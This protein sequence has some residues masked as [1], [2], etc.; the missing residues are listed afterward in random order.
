MLTLTGAI[1]PAGVAGWVPSLIQKLKPRRNIV[2]FILDTNGKLKLT[3][4]HLKL[5]SLLYT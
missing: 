5:K 1:M 2:K 3:V 4:I